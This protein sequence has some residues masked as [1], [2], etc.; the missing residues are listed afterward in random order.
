MKKHYMVAVSEIASGLLAAFVYEPA[1]KGACV[2]TVEAEN[3]ADAK[4][5]AKADHR[6]HCTEAQ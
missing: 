5:I 4:V 6:A 1:P 3:A 2:H